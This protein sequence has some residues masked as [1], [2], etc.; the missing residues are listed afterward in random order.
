MNPSNRHQPLFWLLIA[1]AL[2][3]YV[4]PWVMNPAHVLDLNAYDLAEWL[5]LRPAL[6][7]SFLL[8]GQLLII[9]LLIALSSTPPRRTAGWWLRLIA[10]LVL[11]VAQLPPLEFIRNTADS[12]QQQ[13]FMLAALSVVGGAIGLSTWLASYRYHLLAGL[14][15]TGIITCII[16]IPQALHVMQAYRLPTTIDAGVIGMSAVYGAIGLYA[17]SH[18]RESH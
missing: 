7:T 14:S 8:R 9:T 10:V 18:L 6:A 1:L 12:N 5:S 16:A 2:V 3:A 15:L 13:Q 17:L 11:C 4:L